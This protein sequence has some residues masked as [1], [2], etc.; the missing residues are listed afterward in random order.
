M[1]VIGP[2]ELN[3]VERLGARAVCRYVTYEA[4]KF[5]WFEPRASIRILGHRDN[6]VPPGRST[7]RFLGGPCCGNPHRDSRLLDRRLKA[8]AL[9]VI[10]GPVM[11]HRLAA[12]QPGQ[13]LQAF[14][15]LGCARPP[16]AV[17]AERGVFRIGGVSRANSQDNSSV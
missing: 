17:I 4:T 1:R 3:N 13:H 12:P 15:K 11:L 16:V 2:T 14:V 6:P 8:S 10:V 9:N 5:A 7:Q